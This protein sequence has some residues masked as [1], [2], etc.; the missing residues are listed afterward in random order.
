[1]PKIMI[2]KYQQFAKTNTFFPLFPYTFFPIFA[3][4]SPFFPKTHRNQD[5]GM[6]KN[7][8]GLPPPQKVNC[9]DFSIDVYIDIS[10]RRVYFLQ[11]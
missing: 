5:L 7:G 8:V 9:T 1:M 6:G 10:I 11:K 2:I 3:H 4:F